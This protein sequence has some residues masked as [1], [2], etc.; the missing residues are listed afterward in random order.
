MLIKVCNKCNIE[1]KISEF[2]KNKK[3]VDGVIATCKK[4]VSKQKRN[5]RKTKAGLANSIYENQVGHS[6]KRGHSYPKYSRVEF[7]EFLYS[8]D[9]FNALYDMWVDSNYDKHKVPSVDR[10]DDSIGYSFCNIQITTWIENKNKSHKDMRSGKLKHGN[11]PQKKV[12]K[13]TLKKELI[14]VYPSTSEASR[15]ENYS[16]ASISRFCRGVFCCDKFIFSYKE[17]I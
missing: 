11:N 14:C 1:K 3:M 4:C 2:P 6:K 10:I 16:Q 5:Y 12:Y 7:I 15:N 8:S 17:T 9:K 13:Y